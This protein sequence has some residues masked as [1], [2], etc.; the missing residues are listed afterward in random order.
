MTQETEA[1]TPSVAAREGK[2]GHESVSIKLKSMRTA[3]DRS[4]RCA[5]SSVE[6]SGL[7]RR[8]AAARGR[9]RGIDRHVE[10]IGD[11]IERGADAAGGIWNE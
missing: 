8:A 4:G 1:A 9:D 11:A 5:H 10:R 2:S 3:S 6:D 7:G